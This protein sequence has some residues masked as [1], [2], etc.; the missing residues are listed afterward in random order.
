MGDRSER[1]DLSRVCV[2]AMS[3][4]NANA[5]V[6]IAWRT[7]LSDQRG[8]IFIASIVVSTTSLLIGLKIRELHLLLLRKSVMKQ[9]VAA[10]LLTDALYGL[11]Q[12]YAF[13]SS[14]GPHS[15][16]RPWTTKQKSCFAST[17]SAAD[18]SIINAGLG[19][20][21]RRSGG[22]HTSSHQATTTHLEVS[23]S[24]KQEEG[25]GAAEESEA[26]AGRAL[27]AIRY[28]D[29]RLLSLFG[30]WYLGNYFVSGKVVQLSLVIGKPFRL[31]THTTRNR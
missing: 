24:N 25:G 8:W 15:L 30:L 29:F 16:I 9:F 17:L 3:K 14:S 19:L 1:C 21:V 10:I 18:A 23:S 22:F 2:L 31:R 5:A 7:S 11:G 4:K 13:G 26:L 6:L 20:P 12:A 27:A 28:L